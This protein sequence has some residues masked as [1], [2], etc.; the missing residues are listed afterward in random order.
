MELSEKDWES[1]SLFANKGYAI[2]LITPE[3]LN[4]ASPEKVENRLI[5]LSWDIINDLKD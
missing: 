4:G 3:E 1:L 2:V 5:E